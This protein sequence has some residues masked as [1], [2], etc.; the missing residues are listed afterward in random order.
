MA[1]QDELNQLERV[2]LRLGHAETDDQLQDII[3]KFLPPV[4]L[5]LSSTQEGV[6]KKVMELLVHLN[7]RIKSRPKIQLPV[8]TLLVQYQDPS[9]ASFVTNFTIIYIKMGYPRLEVQKQCELAPTLLTAMEGKPQPQQDGLMHLLIP[10]LFHM[11]YPA[12]PASRLPVQ[13]R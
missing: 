7:K 6:R 13:P 9:A 8:E 10:A 4:L 3:S 11:K 5:K 12:G 1:A 2:F